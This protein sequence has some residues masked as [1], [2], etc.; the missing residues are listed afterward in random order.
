MIALVGMVVVFIV[1]ILIIFCIWLYSKLLNRGTGKKD[2]GIKQDRAEPQEN[3]S[4]PQSNPIVSANDDNEIIAV[5]TAA[6]MACMQ[7][8]G[9]GLLVRSIRRIG[10]TTPIWNIAGRNEQILSRI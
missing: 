5:I 10:H 9:S 8:S 3:V 7:A 2:D 4:L 1:L 6:V